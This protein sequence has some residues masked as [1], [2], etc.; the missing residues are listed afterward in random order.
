MDHSVDLYIPTDWK[1][2]IA[3]HIH[4]SN[5]HVPERVNK[6]GYSWYNKGCSNRIT[7]DEKENAFF[8]PLEFNPGDWNFRQ[9]IENDIRNNKADQLSPLV[10]LNPDWSH[11]YRNA[12]QYWKVHSI[13]WKDNQNF[14][15]KLSDQMFNIFLEVEATVDENG[16]IT[17]TKN[18][19][20]EIEQKG[21]MTADRIKLYEGRENLG[22]FKPKLQEE[23]N[24]GN[25]SDLENRLQ[26][27]E[28][29][30]EKLK[31][32]NTENINNEN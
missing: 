4:G 19:V 20:K 28:A 6:W 11:T 7:Y 13:L 2:N 30:L 16:D 26:S 24:S 29:E 32:Q 12:D 25:N 17:Y 8:C 23:E 31:Q 5:L 1:F 21:M 14:I 10:G 27:L 9:K 22:N 3:N 15:V 18:T